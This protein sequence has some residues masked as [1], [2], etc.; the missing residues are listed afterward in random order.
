VRREA[1]NKQT[2]KSGIN[3][4]QTKRRPFRQYS[5]DAHRPIRQKEK[6]RNPPKAPARNRD[7]VNIGDWIN[8]PSYTVSQSPKQASSEIAA[9][10][11]RP[12]V[13]D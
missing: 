1:S 6:G 3:N 12:P 10:E 5:F 9:P 7:G 13:V 2:N 8:G 4:Q 11:F